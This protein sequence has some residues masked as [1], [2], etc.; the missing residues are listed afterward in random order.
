LIEERRQRD[1]DGRFP[2]CTLL[3]ARQV[4]NT[5]GFSQPVL[6]CL[7]PRRLCRLAAR[8]IPDDPKRRAKKTINT[9]VMRTWLTSRR[10]VEC[11][12]RTRRSS[13]SEVRRRGPKQEIDPPPHRVRTLAPRAHD[14]R[15]AQQEENV[16]VPLATDDDECH[17][18][19]G[20][21]KQPRRFIMPR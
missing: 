17:D 3:A 12:E 6:K 15:R 20:Q 9:G 11:R 10:W 18:V 5:G 16:S 1:F 4:F 14:R 8:A 2:L 19:S 7:H 13:I 21:A